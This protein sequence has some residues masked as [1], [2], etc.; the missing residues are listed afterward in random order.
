[1]RSTTASPNRSL[2]RTRQA[3]SRPRCR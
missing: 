3:C 2:P 1:L